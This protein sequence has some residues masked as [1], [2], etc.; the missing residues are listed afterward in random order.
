MTVNALESKLETG[1]V[2]FYFT[3]KD[4]ST[5]SALGTRNLDLIPRGDLPSHLYNITSA[6][7]YWDLEACAYRSVSRSAE[8]EIYS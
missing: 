1:V 7:V 3:K 5:R 8:V 2:R 6:M 4:G